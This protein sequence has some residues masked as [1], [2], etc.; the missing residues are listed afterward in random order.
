MG[1]GALGTSLLEKNAVAAPAPAGV[2]GPGAVP[3]TLTINGKPVQLTVEPCVT[4]IEAMRNYLDIT[5]AKCACDRGNCGTCTVLMDG[6]S[7][8][9]LRRARHRRPGQADRDH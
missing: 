2:V 6:K 9:S 8:Y 1:G 5:G 3:I 7:V 4:L